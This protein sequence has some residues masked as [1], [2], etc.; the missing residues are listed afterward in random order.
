MIPGCSLVVVGEPGA[1]KS[2]ALYDVSE[3]LLAGGYD[4]ILLAADRS[5]AP[6]LGALRQTLGLEHEVIDVLRSWPGSGPGFL[7]IDG[8]DAARQESAGRTLRD[9]IR[10]VVGLKSRWRVSASVRRFDLRHSAELQDL[11]RREGPPVVAPE[12]REKE[13]E[14]L[15]HLNIPVLHET[16]IAQI[17]EQSL[18]LASL[19]GAASLEL[20]RL[21]RVP[22]NLHLLADLL[23]SGVPIAELVPVR[24][25]I[26][27]LGRY[28][29]ARVK[30]WNGSDDGLSDA[31]EAVLRMACEAMVESRALQVERSR[32]ARAETSVA[33]SQVLSC[34]ML[35]EDETADTLKFEH[36]VLFDYAVARLLL[37]GPVDKLVERIESDPDLTIVI[38]PSIVLHFQYL[39]IADPERE[40]FWKATFA[41][42]AS[43]R[44][45]EIAK[46]VGPS[47][48][49]ELGTSVGDFEILRST[50]RAAEE[51]Q[52]SVAERAVV[53]LMGALLAKNPDELLG[54]NTGPWCG[55]L[56]ALSR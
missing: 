42:I 30:L 49:A 2:G 16:E 47:V 38:R 5:A 15:S 13:F 20:K 52:V 37:R 45:P 18:A 27:L 21:L 53:H 43:D 36:H 44:L 31:R 1:G 46:L 26:E 32:V 19:I 25:Q 11:F 50:T 12:F 51:Q 35:Q 56:E 22:F 7:V 28:W 29:K 9:L 33:L 55:L 34:Q 40:P 41:T 8:L 54:T 17:S 4:V 39:W 48:A 14:S 24:S 3:K 23:S 6:S 10:L